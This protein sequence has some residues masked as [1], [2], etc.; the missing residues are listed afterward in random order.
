M[1]A[2]NRIRHITVLLLAGFVAYF[3]FSNGVIL[4]AWH[5]PLMVIG[6]SLLFENVILLTSESN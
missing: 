1:S 3:S 6:V 2:L 5:P 4:F